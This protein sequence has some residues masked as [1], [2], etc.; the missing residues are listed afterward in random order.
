MY[1]C[2]L[3]LLSP[4]LAL[5]EKKIPVERRGLPLYFLEELE[6]TLGYFF[7]QLL[8]V[9]SIRWADIWHLRLRNTSSAIYLFIFNAADY[10][11]PPRGC[12][13]GF[14]QVYVLSSE[15]A[16]LSEWARGRVCILV[17]IHHLSGRGKC[18][19]ERL[20]A[21]WPGVQGGHLEQGV[22]WG[23]LR[24][25]IVCLKWKHKTD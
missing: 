4:R 25:L 24:W 14:P 6:Y 7:S 16:I 18:T 10:H 15:A 13:H 22:N 19:S 1:S 8:P 3:I 17:T 9:S 23:W 21:H 20:S 5:K 12:S 2:C 11:R